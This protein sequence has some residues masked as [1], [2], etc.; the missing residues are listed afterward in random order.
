MDA[1][2]DLPPG[3]RR[4]DVR[5]A[6][7]DAGVEIAVHDC[8]P[9]LSPEVERVLFEPFVST[10][11]EGIGIGLTIVRAI[12]EAHGGTINARNN[13]EGGATFRFT[14]PAARVA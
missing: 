10:K 13:A 2:A 7:A 14:L 12:V 5:V 11:R 4:V 9:G 1:M 6:R 8:G 3:R